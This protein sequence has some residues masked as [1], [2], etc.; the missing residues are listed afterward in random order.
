MVANGE[1]QMFRAQSESG[2]VSGFHVGGRLVG[3]WTLD[4]TPRQKKRSCGR[5]TSELGATVSAMRDALILVW[6]LQQEFGGDICA[7]GL[8]VTKF[9][10]PDLLPRFGQCPHRGTEKPGH[11]SDLGLVQRDSSSKTWHTVC[12]YTLT[13]SDRRW[14]LKERECF[15]RSLTKGITAWYSS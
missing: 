2:A 11:M 6:T 12:P 4:L 10:E 1:K 15:E 7:P 14:S 3:S 9:V 13:Y 5:V 8:Q